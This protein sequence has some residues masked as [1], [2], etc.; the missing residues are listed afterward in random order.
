MP[1]NSFASSDS[2]SLPGSCSWSYDQFVRSETLPNH[3]LA[4]ILRPEP[5]LILRTMSF[6]VSV[7]A[8]MLLPYLMKLNLSISLRVIRVPSLRMLKAEPW[9]PPSGG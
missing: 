5:F 8:W 7:N 1:S 2:H 3:S 6:Q 9:A 4:S